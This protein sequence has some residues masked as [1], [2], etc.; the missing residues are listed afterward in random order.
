MNGTRNSLPFHAKK[1]PWEAG[2]RVPP[3]ANSTANSARN[4]MQNPYVLDVDFVAVFAAVNP[5]ALRRENLQKELAHCG[6]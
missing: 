6:Y 5:N 4:L 1:P 2:L 3:H